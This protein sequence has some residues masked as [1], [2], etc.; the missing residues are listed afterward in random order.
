ML[1]AERKTCELQCE[2]TSTYEPCYKKL[3]SEETS[4]LK[5]LDGTEGLQEQEDIETESKIEDS[6][7][8]SPCNTVG[9][10]A[11]QE[12]IEGETK[13]DGILPL[14]HGPNKTESKSSEVLNSKPFDP[15][16]G[17][18][19]LEA[20]YDAVSPTKQKTI[21][22]ESKS[23][24]RV[25]PEQQKIETGLQSEEVS[26]LG[27]NGKLEVP[28][29]QETT[30]SESK[31]V[32]TSYLVSR[33]SL[34]P[35][36]LQETIE[37]ESKETGSA[38]A[39]DDKNE[40][41]SHEAESSDVLETHELEPSILSV[42]KA[43][44]RANVLEYESELTDE[45]C[46]KKC[47]TGEACHLILHHRLEGPLPKEILENDQNKRECSN[48]HTDG[49]SVKT[50][51]ETENSDVLKTP[52]SGSINSLQNE[53][54]SSAAIENMCPF[55][56]EQECP[57]LT[58][59]AELGSE[60]NVNTLLCLESQGKSKIEKYETS[61]V[62][63]GPL[64]KTD[65]KRENSIDNTKV[66]AGESSDVATS[67]LFNEAK[68]VDDS[69][70]KS[71]EKVEIDNELSQ[72]YKELEQLEDSD[73]LV[74]SAQENE[75][76]LLVP[77]NKG[78]AHSSKAD[79]TWQSG[80]KHKNIYSYG[81]ASSGAEQQ[82]GGHIQSTCWNTSMPPPWPSWQQP[83]TLSFPQ[84]PT[85]TPYSHNLTYQPYPTGTFSPQVTYPA[86]PNYAP[87]S[88]NYSTPAYPGSAFP[89]PSSA[90]YSSTYNYAAYPGPTPASSFPPP[91]N[92]PYLSTPL[93]SSLPPAPP[94]SFL[95]PPSSLPP[96]PISLL[97]PSSLPP[98]PPPPPSSLPLPPPSSLPPPPPSSLPPPPPSSFPPPP[99]S[100]F[101]P[102]PSSFP[103][104]PSSLLPPPS[105]LPLPPL[106][107]LPPP[108]PPPHPP[109]PPPP[110]H[111]L[112]PPASP[113]PPPGS[114][115][116]RA[117]PAST[118][119]LPPP[120]PL[121]PP[122]SLPLPSNVPPPTVSAFPH[123]PALSIPCSSASSMPPP[124]TNSLP[125]AP[126]ANSLPPAPT[127]SLP[128]ATVSIIYPPATS[129][130]SIRPPPSNYFIPPNQT[131]TDSLYTANNCR[132]P[133]NASV[134][135]TA[136]VATSSPLP[137]ADPPGGDNHLASALPRQGNIS[138][139]D[140][141]HGVSTFPTGCK[142]LSTGTLGSTNMLPS[143]SNVPSQ[144][145]SRCGSACPSPLTTPPI[146]SQHSANTVPHLD[147]PPSAQSQ[148]GTKFHYSRPQTPVSAPQSASTG[149]HANADKALALTTLPPSLN[150][151]NFNKP[152]PGSTFS[153]SR[154]GPPANTIDQGFT[155]PPP[156][157]GH[158]LSTTKE[159]NTLPPP[160][161]GLYPN[162]SCPSSTF[163]PPRNVPLSDSPNFEGPFPR[164]RI[165]PPSNSLGQSG[166][167]SSSGFG[168]PHSTPHL[169]GNLPSPRNGPS[170]S[171][172]YP[173]TSTLSS[174][175]LAPSPSLPHPA[176]NIPSCRNGDNYPS[177]NNGPPPNT[178]RVINGAP[179]L[180]YPPPSDEIYVESDFP[181]SRYCPP[182]SKQ[183]RTNNGSPARQEFSRDAPYTANN[184]LSSWY[185]PPKD[186]PHVA[187]EFPPS[188]SH[189]D[190]PSKYRSDQPLRSKIS[191]R[192]RSPKET[193]SSE[194]TFFP[195]VYHHL[196]GTLQSKKDSFSSR[197]RPTADLG[198]DFHSSRYSPSQDSSDSENDFPPPQYPPSND[199]T[200]A[201]AAFYQPPDKAHSENDFLPLK[202]RPSSSLHEEIFY[203]S[204]RFQLPD[205]TQ[206]TADDFH[207]SRYRAPV[208]LPDAVNKFPS[209]R[210]ASPSDTRFTPTTLPLSR[211]GSPC[212]TPHSEITFPPSRRGCPPNEPSHLFSSLRSRSPPNKS[213][214][215]SSFLS[216]REHHPH[217]QH[218]PCTSPLRSNEPHHNG[219]DVYRKRNTSSMWDCSKSVEKNESSDEDDMYKYM[220]YAD[221]NSDEDVL[222]KSDHHCKIKTEFW[223]EHEIEYKSEDVD[224][225]S[226]T[227]VPSKPSGHKL[228][229]L[230]RGVP[231]SGKTT[232]ANDLLDK[233][234][235]GTVL[236]TDDFFRQRDGYNFVGK[237]L[238]NAHE[239]NQDRAMKAMDEGRT[240][241][242][243][244]NTNTQAWEM[245]PYVEMAIE[246]GYTV[247][248]HEPETWW[249]RD[250]VELE[251]RNTHNV[252]RDKISQMVERYEH[253]MSVATV[254]NSKQPP[255]KIAERSF[256]RLRPKRERSDN[257]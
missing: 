242:I 122:G 56:L 207:P 38:K 50:S 25:L 249:K 203:P 79:S 54:C 239:W 176:T 111:S 28:P 215:G 248:F 105:S 18:P 189:T 188:R 102:P 174:T 89:P 252:P 219:Y 183:E 61:K 90:P 251:K 247:Q 170:P 154:N 15:L 126:P 155:L 55:Q 65:L 230:L 163:P 81:P 206:C 37:R 129:A 4:H 160:R 41:T 48:V 255:H 218:R 186:D 78:G 166:T 199:A 220:A 162:T 159:T 201:S 241:V 127:C 53:S 131:L 36:Q 197:Y 21:E 151:T 71:G 60:E 91:S 49:E 27:L 77:Q 167:F 29:G 69:L 254:M 200:L 173:A 253:Y 158:L 70:I 223:K 133:I 7:D 51:N 181:P 177:Q 245:K 137:G 88:T 202:C 256:R 104:P 175:R 224:R 196:S 39:C 135:S 147:K 184:F 209:S 130:S 57:P 74:D 194:C 9:F 76:S 58:E 185:Q 6:F 116:P 210:Y 93:T 19:S 216:T 191:S 221:R 96:P 240:P 205:E 101:P 138:P 115:F 85:F 62:F 211:Y 244:D 231:G 112:P 109:P 171:S 95:P 192:C 66:G 99:P 168:P 117:S 121:R 84:G 67:K 178:P 132:P 10:S 153:S 124:L 257:T 87:L 73:D 149:Y 193:Q 13:S 82:F 63:I 139:F 59:S 172:P 103:P 3:K 225:F 208:D 5:P 92:A 47:K 8:C 44:K 12:K 100:S 161:K 142:D 1:N 169:T 238:G 140:K 110:P 228:L 222:S 152:Q 114:H 45:P 232:L 97:P 94:S 156:R 119:S 43:E 250:P 22:I 246:R 75:Q 34:E 190:N 80:N 35:V 106:S 33:S 237:K 20:K 234:P 113:F 17:S 145:A 143:F 212:D 107:S 233:S 108:P 182:N 157:V 86:Y 165:E 144:D 128:S 30:G 42:Q 213:F 217:S 68:K 2:K 32:A 204:S 120:G 164:S 83:Q 123:Q 141:T 226:C 179:P 235:E 150:S 72:F 198:K 14:G 148:P 236:S 98:P 24:E 16:K 118:F 31:S 187:V 214:V 195:S 229:I 46:S 180:N 125:P 11:T 64:C 136:D 40:E 26:N 227:A 146:F 243:I 134:P 23:D 52:E